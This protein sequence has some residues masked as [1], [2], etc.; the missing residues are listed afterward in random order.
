[1]K[2]LKIATIATALTA[3]IIA[4]CGITMT[5]TAETADT[6]T[7]TAVVTAWEQIGDTALK[8]ITVTD[9]DGNE[10]DFFDDEEYW[11]IGDLA[12]VTLWDLHEA[13]ES[14]EVIDVE[15]IDHLEWFA[16]FNWLDKVYE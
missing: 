11:Q 9:E 8:T 7:K 10:W 14:D 6:Y 2:N 5:A 12:I 13:E 3:L 16:L 1:M 15:K 4:L